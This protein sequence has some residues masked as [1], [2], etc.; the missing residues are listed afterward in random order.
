MVSDA[1]GAREFVVRGDGRNLIDFMYIDDAVDGLLTLVQAH[2]TTETIDFASRTP[3]TVNEAVEAMTRAVGVEAAIRHEGEAA[4]YIQFRS[5]DTTMSF[6]TLDG[7]PMS[8]WASTVN[9]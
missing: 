7:L 5:V 9:W 4:E 8:S 6:S 2:G 1:A 3:L